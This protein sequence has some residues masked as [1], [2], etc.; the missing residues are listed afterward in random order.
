MHCVKYDT[1]LWELNGWYHVIRSRCNT[2]ATH[3]SA[4]TVKEDYVL[5]SDSLKIVLGRQRQKLLKG[6]VL[7]V[8]ATNVKFT[9]SSV[10]ESINIQG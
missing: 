5:E 4:G 10:E 7:E 1:H 9:I 2:V 3:L 8:K 6:Y